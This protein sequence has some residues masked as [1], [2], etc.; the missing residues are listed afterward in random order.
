MYPD[1]EVVTTG[2]GRLTDAHSD[3]ERIDVNDIA[4]MS[5]MLALFILE[6]GGSTVK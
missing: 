3:S 2:P 4:A 6:H 1:L 5:A